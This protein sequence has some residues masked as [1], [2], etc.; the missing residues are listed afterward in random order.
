M[1]FNSREEREQYVIALYKQGKTIGEIAQEVH[2]SFGSIGAVIRKLTGEQNNKEGIGEQLKVNEL[3]KE[4]QAFTLFSEGKTSV[5]VVIQLDIKPEE[6]ETL[7]LGFLRL[8]GLDKLVMMYKESGLDVQLPLNFFRII[9]R[10]GMNDQDIMNIMEFA[11]QILYL[12]DIYE[13]L[14]KDVDDLDYKNANSLKNYLFC[15]TKRVV[16]RNE[17]FRKVD[18]Y[19]C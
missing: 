17:N 18:L 9:K 4:A 5:D 6:A 15:K 10:R 1:F 11:K 19:Y 12:K 14:V 8:S 13:Q 16:D 3:S 7:Y 2:M